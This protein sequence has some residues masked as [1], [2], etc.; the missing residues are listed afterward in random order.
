MPD[1]PPSSSLPED[2][3]PMP[4]PAESRADAMTSELDE[5]KLKTMYRMVEDVM[6]ITD[7]QPVMKKLLYLSDNQAAALS[8]VDS[9]GKVFGAL[10]LRKPSFV[11]KLLNCQGG[12]T[13]WSAHV[14]YKG[15]L[16][17]KLMY[18][19]EISQRDESAHER[20]LVKFMS[21]RRLTKFTTH[22]HFFSA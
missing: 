5:I 12:A 4:P 14:E 19:S 13:T 7:G 15:R 22:A 20:L 2:I 16:T 6:V 9:M 10:E 21:V 11:I 8:T 3:A 18:S 1:I 17:E